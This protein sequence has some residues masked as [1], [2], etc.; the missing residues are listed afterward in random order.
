MLSKQNIEGNFA[1]KRICHF[2][3]GSVQMYSQESFFHFFFFFNTTS[4][5]ITINSPLFYTPT[6]RSKSSDDN[7]TLMP[8]ATL[9]LNNTNI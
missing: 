7:S 2:D 4:L 1:G 3:T 5:F 6:Y 9:C 8:I